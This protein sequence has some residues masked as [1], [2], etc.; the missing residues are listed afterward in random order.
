MR[1]GLFSPLFEA[2][3]SLLAQQGNEGDA[4]FGRRSSNL[5]VNE[6]VVEAGL[7]RR[8]RVAAKNTRAGRAQ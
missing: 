1:F 6:R 5:L 7:R 8:P 4:A 2:G 3:Q